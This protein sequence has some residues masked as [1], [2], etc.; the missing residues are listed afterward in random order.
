M[1]LSKLQL[2]ELLSVYGAT[3]TDKQREVATM[4]CDCDCS[5]SEIADEFG[6]TR[7]GARDAIVKSEA[8]LVRLENALHL[9]EF[10]RSLTIAL[11]GDDLIQ[12]KQTVKQFVSKE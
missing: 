2:S 5:L 7:Q 12:L 3:L 8:S 11:D 6:I 4:Y 10:C 9:A 1:A